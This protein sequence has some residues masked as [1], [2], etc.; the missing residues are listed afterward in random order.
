MYVNNF[1]SLND[2]ERVYG[3]SSCIS[4][5]Y[6]FD[7]QSDDCC[8]IYSNLQAAIDNSVIRDDRVYW[9]KRRRVYS[10]TTQLA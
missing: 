7:D 5:D 4:N 10:I 3:G 9:G 2:S 8:T 1:I 6:C